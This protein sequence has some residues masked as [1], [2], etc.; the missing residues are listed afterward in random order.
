MVETK[1]LA[2]PVVRK[3]VE[4]VN[5][6]DRDAFFAL[7]TEDATMSDDGSDRD[8]D[9][10]GRPRD[11]LRRRAHGGRVAVRRRPLAGRQLHELDLRDDA[12][13]LEVHGRGRQ[14]RPL[15][16]RPGRLTQRLGPE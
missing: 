14:G 1:D 10:V 8:L 7:L 11:L 13:R 6:G 16:D 5:A 9:R 2:D 4:A 3:L 12:D 15:R